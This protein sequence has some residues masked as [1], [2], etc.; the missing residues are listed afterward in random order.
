[1][2]RPGRLAVL[3]L[4][5]LA[6]WSIWW[7]RHLQTAPPPGRTASAHRIDYTMEKFDVTAM[8]ASGNPQYHLQADS[9]THYADDDS[10]EF[11]RPRI[12]YIAKNSTDLR[13]EGERGWMASQGDEIRLLGAVRIEGFAKQPFTLLTRDVSFKP[14]DSVAE[15]QAAVVLT[16]AGV[17]V[18][19]VGLR[20]DIDQER[21]QL[22]AKV[23]GRYD[24]TSH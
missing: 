24:A 21:V 15:T 13:L 16:T 22:L 19:A 23:Q 10:S 8:D 6:A 3:A 4:A 9:M 18:S 20:V 11:V 7:L 17:R 12:E 14:D 2:M 5:L 1:M